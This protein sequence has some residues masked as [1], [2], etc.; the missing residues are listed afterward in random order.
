MAGYW[1]VLWTADT[2][3]M[4]SNHIYVSIFSLDMIDG[5]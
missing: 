4:L 2:S 3:H 1:N 5:A